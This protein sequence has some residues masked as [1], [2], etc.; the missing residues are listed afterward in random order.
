ML[1]L[2]A[3]LH[4]A[5]LVS[6][7]PLQSANDRSRWATV[8]SLVE[9]GTFQ[10]DAIDQRPGWS[11][12]DKVQVDGHLYSS[13]PALLPVITAG[14]YAAVKAVTGWSLLDQT[15]LV[16]QTILVMMN[17]IPWIIA[18]LAVVAMVRKYAASRFTR[19]FV[20]ATTV[21]GTYLSAYSVTLNN[22]TIAATSL[23]FALFFATRI[24]IDES[25]RI[26]DFLLCGL[27][28]AFVTTNELP[29]ALF[30]LALFGLLVRND[31]KRTCFLFVPAAL[32]PIGAFFVTT[33][34]QTGTWKPFY[35]SYG[36]DTYIFIRDGLPSYW[37]F[38]HGIDRN[39]DSLPTYLFHCLFGHH[40]ILSHTPVFLL[41]VAGWCGIKRFGHRSLWPF[42]WMGMGLTI[43]I[44]AFY[45]T[46]TQNYNYSGLTAALR[47]MLWLIPFWI[48][49][50]IPILDAMADHWWLRAV[51]LGLLA[52]STFSAWDAADN[53]W[54]PSWLYC[55][56]EA[57]G[58]ID[59]DD[60]PPRL[61]RTLSTVISTL[62]PAGAE[63]ERE[64]I[65]LTATTVSGEDTIRL[66]LIEAGTE[67]VKT[68]WQF[69]AATEIGSAEDRPS[70]QAM[71]DRSAFKS[72]AMPAECIVSAEP[73]KELAVRRYS[74]LPNP[75]TLRPRLE[76]FVKIPG[77][78][79]AF[80][81]TRAT[82]IVDVMN[83]SGELI[84]HRVDVWVCPDVP[85]G[86]IR[87]QYTLQKAH[88]GQ[89]LERRDYVLSDAGRRKIPDWVK[90][91]ESLENASKP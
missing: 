81:A 49:G 69:L 1:A 18:W 55:V 8:W 17:L 80:R 90:R 67:R 59:Y 47:W 12:I 2:A 35:L 28:A 19:V 10:I 5:M 84:R 62:P 7:D 52:V 15:A 13:K 40:G 72:G 42:I 89:V 29:A 34:L 37:A 88:N 60:P 3:G 56:M 45:L 44:L 63:S 54:R 71:W 76:R 82:G 86:V 33:W 77:F 66:S 36:T 85:F 38:P 32:V 57:Q 58:W 26:S 43:A 41:T 64:W 31:W 21:A 78:Q 9:Q 46:R 51:A 87:L 50:L 22:H 27:T 20:I 70:I 73:S 11:T 25:R 61:E 24:V 68:R 74:G 39:I 75:V 16:T 4:L 79:Y 53:P 14:F 48:L 23:I 91:I 30:G 83:E 65:E 6:A